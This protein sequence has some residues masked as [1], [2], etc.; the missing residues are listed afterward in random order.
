MHDAIE[1]EGKKLLLHLTLNGR[2]E[3]RGASI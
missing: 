1:N 3:G 2:Y